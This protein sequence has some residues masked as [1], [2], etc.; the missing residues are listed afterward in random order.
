MKPLATSFL[1][2]ASV[3]MTLAASSTSSTPPIRSTRQTIASSGSSFLPTGAVAGISVGVTLA[4]VLLAVGPFLVWRRRCKAT[5][6]NPLAAKPFREGE[7][8][9]E[10]VAVA[11]NEP[12]KVDHTYYETD[13][14]GRAPTGGQDRNA[15]CYG[16][17]AKEGNDRM[18]LAYSV[19]IL[20]E[21]GVEE[22][23]LDTVETVVLLP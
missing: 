11:A 13:G 21:D 15:E 7:T 14:R 23:A 12:W 16:Q 1:T 8:D 20:L 18:N 10:L 6:A 22:I 3:A 2:F 9:K 5:K 4:V 19:H 17:G